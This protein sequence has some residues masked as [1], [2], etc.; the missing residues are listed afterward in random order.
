M[1]RWLSRRRRAVITVTLVALAAAG[2]LAWGPVGLG[3]GPLSAAAGRIVSGPDPGRKPLAVFIMITNAGRSPAVVQSIQLIGDA[4][5]FPG[6]HVFATRAVAYQRTPCDGAWPIQRL[7]PRVVV[8][9]DCP[10]TDPDPIAG[11]SVPFESGP[12]IFAL[13]MAEAR[14]PAPDGCWVITTVIVHYRVGIRYY[15]AAGSN[16]II[17]CSPGA[18]SK[19]NAATRAAEN[20]G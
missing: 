5:G 17:S 2:F 12:R 16:D 11:L 14:P 19:V 6:P 1:R 3:N 20:T 15:T 18:R 13:V 8:S 10:V 9:P 7:R 4:A